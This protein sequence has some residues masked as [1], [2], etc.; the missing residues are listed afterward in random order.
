M[1]NYQGKHFG[2]HYDDAVC[3]DGY[4]WDADSGDSNGL[5]SGGDE[6]CPSCNLR[7]R[8]RYFQDEIEEN[9][10]CSIEQP[11]TFPKLFPKF[12]SSPASERRLLRRFWMRG[13]KARIKDELSYSEDN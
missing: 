7:E 12:Q 3:I 10:Y 13:R 11:F 6:P 4:L 8:T 1:C 2:A 5:T 9:G